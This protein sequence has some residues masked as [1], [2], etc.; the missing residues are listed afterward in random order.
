M[1]QWQYKP[2]VQGGKAQRQTGILVQLDFK[3]ATDEDESALNRQDIEKISV[4]KTK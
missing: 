2:R 4:A 1:K 3:L